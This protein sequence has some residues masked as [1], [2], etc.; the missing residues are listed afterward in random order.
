MELHLLRHG[1]TRWNEL[2]K[3]M[4]HS[5]ISLSSEGQENVS[6]QNYFEHKDLDDL[7]IYSSDLSRCL[8]TAEII[9]CKQIKEEPR[10][11][12]R[13]FGKWEGLTW[14]QIYDQNPNLPEYGA[15]EWWDLSPPEGESYQEMRE[16][17]LEALNEIIQNDQNTLII[18]HSGPLRF[19]TAELLDFD[20]MKS[21][22]EIHFSNNGYLNFNYDT[23]IVTSNNKVELPENY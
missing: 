10:L 13:S 6:E 8:E 15:P 21:I 17:T 12:E 18:S 19:I 23:S 11:R 14:N 3:A 16:R 9:G 4:G 22:N 7:D 2:N 1:K 5:D 20:P